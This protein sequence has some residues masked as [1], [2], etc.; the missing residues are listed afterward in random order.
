MA[1][2]GAIMA[3]TGQAMAPE[4]RAFGMAVF[5]SAMYPI[6]ALAPISGGWLYDLTGDVRSALAVG[7]ALFVMTIISY[8]AFRWMV[9]R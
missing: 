7:T 2:A 5:Y 1:P 6:T 4:R 3:L 9:K 8:T